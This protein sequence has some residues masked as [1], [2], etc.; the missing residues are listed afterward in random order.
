MPLPSIT[1]ERLKHSRNC[2]SRSLP[3]L[4]GYLAHHCLGHARRQD[5]SFPE[6]LSGL[7]CLGCFPP[8]LSSGQNY[9]FLRAQLQ[10]CFFGYDPRLLPRAILWTLLYVSQES[11]APSHLFCS[12]YNFQLFFFIWVSF[13]ELELE[14]VP[15]SLWGCV[16]GPRWLALA[17]E[18]TES[19]WEQSSGPV[20]WSFVMSVCEFYFSLF[21]KL[22]VWKC[23]PCAILF[24]G[25]FNSSFLISHFERHGNEMESCCWMEARPRLEKL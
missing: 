19:S 2:E 17:A 23:G 4:T 6:Q 13:L 11:W 22:V 10:S 1:A 16:R 5:S 15:P 8:S 24:S 18:I 3:F 25:L 20:C 14:A 12:L 9:S 7:N 21:W